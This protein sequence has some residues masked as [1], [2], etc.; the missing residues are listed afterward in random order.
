MCGATGTKAL[1]EYCTFGAAVPISVIPRG[2]LGFATA[3]CLCESHWLA[4]CVRCTCHCNG[5]RDPAAAVIQAFI[6]YV[7]DLLSCT[8]HGQVVSGIHLQLIHLQLCTHADNG[9][10][11]FPHPQLCL[12]IERLP[13]VSCVG[14][15]VCLVV[16]IGHLSSAYFCLGQLYF[17]EVRYGMAAAFK[18]GCTLCWLGGSNWGQVAG[19]QGSL[20]MRCVH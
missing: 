6:E 13:K 17:L 5:T 3:C 14:L 11:F 20:A 19:C 4:G 18:K 16:C 9:H 12:C 1:Q 10:V 8:A 2:M 7:L 15:C